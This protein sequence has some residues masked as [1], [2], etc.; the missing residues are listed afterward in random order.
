MSYI[1]FVY[2]I[3]MKS[4]LDMILTEYWEVEQLTKSIT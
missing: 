1:F 2:N 4:V 3:S